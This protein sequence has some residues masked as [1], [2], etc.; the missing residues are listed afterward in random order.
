MEVEQVRNQIRNVVQAL[1]TIEVR[2]VDNM[3]TLVGSI[4]VLDELYGKLGTAP[5]PEEPD[6]K[7]AKFPG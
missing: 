5:S 6:T 7:I 2:G 3:K 4:M 1:Q